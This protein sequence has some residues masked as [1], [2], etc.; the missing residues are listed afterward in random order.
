MKRPHYSQNLGWHILTDTLYIQMTDATFQRHVDAYLQ[1]QKIAE[2]TL[3]QKIEAR[4]YC[5]RLSFWEGCNDPNVHRHVL[6]RNV[7]GQR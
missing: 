5:R 7:S 4:Q 3:D 2:P 6:R 1:Q